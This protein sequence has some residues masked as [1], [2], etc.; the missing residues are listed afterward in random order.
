MPVGAGSDP[1]PIR[2]PAMQPLEITILSY[3]TPQR[4]AMRRTVQAAYNELLKT[5]PD[6]QIQVT[7]IKE[8]QEILR[9][10]QVLILPS[11][12]VNGKLV[13]VGRFPKKSETL[14]WFQNAIAG[15]VA[16]QPE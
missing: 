12:G 11:L 10:T 8:V 9:Y 2:E 15:N 6:I 1:M 16:P 7:E 13:C 5:C 14:G 3:K 4:Y